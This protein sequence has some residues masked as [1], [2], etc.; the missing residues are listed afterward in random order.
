MLNSLLIEVNTLFTVP[1]ISPIKFSESK[2]NTLA[3][4]VGMV[5]LEQIT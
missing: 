1:L 4:Q 5:T 2:L 3:F